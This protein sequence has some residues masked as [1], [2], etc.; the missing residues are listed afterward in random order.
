M[1]EETKPAEA[2]KEKKAPPKDFVVPPKKPKLSKAERR[3]LQEAQRSAK[4]SGD[5]PPKVMAQQAPPL[6]TEIKLE[7]TAASDQTQAAPVEPEQAMKDNKTVDLFRHLPQF[8]GT[9]DTLPCFLLVMELWKW[10][11]LR[12]DYEY[13]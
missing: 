7:A 13:L 1:T 2:Q 8:R 12:G 9:W 6:Q 11:D 3:A 10:F 4:A 5:E